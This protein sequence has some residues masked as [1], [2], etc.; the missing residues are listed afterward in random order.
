MLHII[1]TLCH[2]QNKAIKITTL[3]AVF[4]IINLV[5]KLSFYETQHTAI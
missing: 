5:L 2:I 1:E 4:E 3:M